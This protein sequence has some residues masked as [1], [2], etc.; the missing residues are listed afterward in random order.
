MMNEWQLIET[1]P[2]DG[3]RLLVCQGEF[4]YIAFFQ[5]DTREWRT[6]EHNHLEVFFG[7]KPTHWRPLPEPPEVEG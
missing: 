2:K 7:A 6:E 5:A 1:A 3:E 4:V